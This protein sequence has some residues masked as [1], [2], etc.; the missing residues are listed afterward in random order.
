LN[1]SA[2]ETT[3][4]TTLAKGAGINFLGQLIAVVMIFLTNVA[5]ARLLGSQEFG[6]FSIGWTFL[7]LIRL[8]SSFGLEKGVVRYG[9]LHWQEDPIQLRT[10]LWQSIGM[11]MTFALISS[12]LLFFSAP[13]IATNVF[14]KPQLIV[15][16]RAFAIILILVAGLRITASATRIT[17]KMQY[18]VISSQI[19]EPTATIVFVLIAVWLFK[20]GLFGALIAWGLA[21]ITALL[22]STWQTR[23]L[24]PSA[25][26]IR[27]KVSLFSFDILL[28]SIL[29]STAGMVL[30]FNVWIDRLLV[31]KFLEAADAGIYI[32][33]TQLV[34]LF[35]VVMMIFKGIFAPMSARF[36]A[37]GQHERLE[38]L[39]RVST[40]WGLYISFALFLI[41]VFFPQKIMLVTFGND[42]VSGSSTL[43]ILA[44]TCLFRAFPGAVGILLVMTGNQKQ[45]FVLSIAAVSSNIVFD[46]LLIPPY[47]INGAAFATMISMFVLFFLGLLQVKL[48]LNMNPFD[49][50]YL[51][52]FAATFIA[53]LGL[54][55]WRLVAP[56]SDL[57]A[58]A[59]SCALSPTIFILSLYFLGFDREDKIILRR[60]KRWLLS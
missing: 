4:T 40:K 48:R 36:Y 30:K 34:S 55:L 5:L 22:V 25:F 27:S 32:A 52:G 57:L 13:Y 51:K 6:L 37:E 15:V 38:E 21:Y 28:F 33:A 31:G 39:Y 49:K 42:Y 8:I 35:M 7:R 47:G 24:F 17:Q 23:R 56:Q 10:V 9:S 46:I 12:V 2:D 14:H 18:S 16:L 45:W 60:F 19:V 26:T 53:A 50:R 1:I 29:S 58:V 43:V 41:M 3:D 11:T 20:G 44:W 59:G 54:Y